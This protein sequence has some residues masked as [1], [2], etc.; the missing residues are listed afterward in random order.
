MQRNQK[1]RKHR[2]T[3]SF[4]RARN[5]DWWHETEKII[6]NNAIWKFNEGTDKGTAGEQEDKKDLG[7]MDPSE[8]TKILDAMIGANKVEEDDKNEAN[9]NKICK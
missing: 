2:D 6:E 9:E 4:Y 8:L 3:Q 1:V 7:R 5:A